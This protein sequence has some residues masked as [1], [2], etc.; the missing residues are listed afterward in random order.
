MTG[1]ELARELER[2]VNNYNTEERDAFVEGFLRMHP[3]LMQSA[4]GLML[5]CV[6]A[7]ANKQYVDGRNQASK[8]TAQLIIKGHKMAMVEKLLKD[9]PNYWTREKA[10]DHVNADYFKLSTLP[11][12]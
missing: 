1:Q 6:E 8:E 10:E 7:M 3:T 4:F 11:F 12:I 5:K 9:E 2:L